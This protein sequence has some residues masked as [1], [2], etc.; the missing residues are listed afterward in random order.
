MQKKK[1]FRRR[2]ENEVKKTSKNIVFYRYLK[3]IDIFKR[4][5]FIARFH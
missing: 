4:M 2:F 5:T 3:S 1:K